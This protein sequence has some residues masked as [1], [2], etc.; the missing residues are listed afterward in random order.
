MTEIRVSDHTDA[1]LIAPHAER[2]IAFVRGRFPVPSRPLS[3]PTSVFRDGSVIEMSFNVMPG[4]GVTETLH[5]KEYRAWS[6]YVEADFDRTY[7]SEMRNSPSHLIFLTAEAHAQKLAYI[8]IAESFERPYVPSEPEYFKIWW[9]S[10]HCNV[11]EM[12][13]DEQ[14]LMQVLWVTE[15]VQTGPKAYSLEVY[16]RIC[17]SM[18]L[19]GRASVFRT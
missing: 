17:G 3:D 15:F 2:A 6:G 12:I 11:P 14:D 8:A 9:T 18:E 4:R 5:C 1:E 7:K 10:A 16:S 19:W 13:R